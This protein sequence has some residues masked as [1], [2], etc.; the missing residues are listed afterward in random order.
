MVRCQAAEGSRRLAMLRAAG[1]VLM[2]V[3]GSGLAAAPP[4]KASAAS[5]P[6]APRQLNVA[7]KAWSGDFDA[8]LARRLIRVD[9]PLS[10]SLY[11][12][13]RGR[14]RG[15]SAE[16]VR[17][18]E[19]WV[20]KT[21]A[22]QLVKRP[23]T[24]Y[25]VPTTRDML[26][27][28]L[29]AGLGDIALG[30]LSVTD[31]RRQLVDFV[32]PD[33]NW[34]NVEILV[35]GSTGPTVA[36]LDDLSGQ[37]V[38]VRET[39]SYH[40]SLV[41]LNERLR[42][43]GKAP[44]KLLLV[45]DALED[46]DMLEMAN[47][48]LIGA[49]VVDSWKARMWAQPLS[50]LEVHRDIVLREATPVGWAIR[51]NSPQL[52]AVLNRFYAEW[53]KK[54]GVIPYRMKQY[55]KNIKAM[56]NASASADQQRFDRTIAL[57]EKYGQMYGFDPLM[58]AAQ[59][60]QESTL[61]QNRKSHVG[62]IGVMQIMPAT[63]KGLQVGD[64]RQIEPNIHAGA[65]YMDQL[66]TRYFNDANFSEGNRTLFAFASYNAGPGNIAK[67]RVE[68]ARRGLDPD[69]WFNHVEPITAE[70]IGIETTTYVRNI[71]KYY[72]S[73]KLSVEAQRQRDDTLKQQAAP[74]R[75]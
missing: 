45:P 57:F 28:N 65:K 61:D 50:K 20:N 43:A 22:R 26:L 1:L 6:A 5:P 24:V 9:V 18:F 25:I 66:M 4:G 46:E 73:Y 47:A 15:L 29:S 13:D 16:L 64:I 74:A 19:R 23:L 38:H 10:R 2:A 44:A 56:H 27:S 71:Y 21:Y 75:K 11:F 63:G 60:Y 17:D 70:K 34:T 69:K 62:A 68:A 53:A 51:K 8:M 52:E 48:G 3:C 59:G 35:T 39:S 58:L 36:S 40:A 55:L 7:S 41:A 42:A 12:V 30:N 33:P 37:D 67:M 72:V 32:V 49:M 14:E 54:S 31:E